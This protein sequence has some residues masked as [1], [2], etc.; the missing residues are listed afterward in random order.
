[1]DAPWRNGK[2]ER[3]GK[4]CKKDCHKTT[5]DGPEAQTWTDFEEDCDAV[6]Q[7]R[8]SKITDSGYSAYPRVFARNLPQME[9]AI[10][11]CGGADLGVVSRDPKLGQGEQPPVPCD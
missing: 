3:A 7:V 5:Q 2:T 10:L 9:D 11:E 4:D 8:A 6:N 1:M